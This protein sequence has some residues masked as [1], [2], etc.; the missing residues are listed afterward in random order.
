MAAAG[1][2]SSS[3]S[4]SIASCRSARAISRSRRRTTRGSTSLYERFEFKQLAAEDRAGAAARRCG[5]RDCGEGA[6]DERGRRFDEP[7]SARRPAPA[8]R[9]TSNTKRCSTM[10]RS[11]AGWRRSSAPSSSCFDTETTSLDPMTARDRRRLARDRA[12]P[13]RA[14]SRSRIAIP[15]RPTSSTATRRS[16]DSAPGSPMRAQR[17]ARPER[18]V[19]PARARQPR[20]RAGRRRARHAARSRTCS[21]RT[22]PHDMDSLAW[23]QLD[24]KT[25]TYDEV[26]GKGAEQI[27]FDQVSVER[28]TEYSAEDV[29]V[30]VRLHRSAASARRRRRRSSIAS[31]ARSRCRCARCCSGWSATAS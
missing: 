28:A 24:W 27:C 14:T 17:E 21:S 31:I 2:A 26:C 30:T 16:R 7:R 20:P 8:S 15:A 3:P 23:R 22:R 10:P 25:L 13:A 19:R 6:R 4:R 18:E 29:D 1:Q 9:R 11:S 12:G 5:R